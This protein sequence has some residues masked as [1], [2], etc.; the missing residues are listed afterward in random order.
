MTAYDRVRRHVR[1]AGGINHRKMGVQKKLSLAVTP[2]KSLLVDN[3]GVFDP[4]LRLRRRYEADHAA[5]MH[6]VFQ[7]MVS[8]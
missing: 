6:D 3:D 4:Y 2:A 5:Q 1:Q 7:G 8:S